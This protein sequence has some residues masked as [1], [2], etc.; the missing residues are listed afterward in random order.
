M[1]KRMFIDPAKQQAVEAK[2]AF[3]QSAPTSLHPTAQQLANR[4]LAVGHALAAAIP[5]LGPWAAQVG[6]TVGE[7]AGT[8]DIAG[9]SGTSAG[10]AALALAPKVGGALLGASDAIPRVLR[11]LVEKTREAQKAATE[12]ADEYANAIKQK[13][14]RLPRINR[15]RARLRRLRE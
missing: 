2:Q 9:A 3:S 13:T 15:K 6:Q 7:Q 10:N 4:Q 11:P 5:V 8:G 12:S 1:A 14:G